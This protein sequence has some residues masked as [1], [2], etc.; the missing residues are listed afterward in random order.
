MGSDLLEWTE[1]LGGYKLGSWTVL[2][3][4]IKVLLK[5][6]HWTLVQT[7]HSW[8]ILPASYSHR[9]THTS[10]PP[11]SL[12]YL[13]KGT[14]QLVATLPSRHPPNRILYEYCFFLSLPLPVM[15]SSSR[16]P[17]IS[18]RLYSTRK[19]DIYHVYFLQS[20]YHRA[21]PI[22]KEGGWVMEE[23]REIPEEHLHTNFFLLLTTLEVFP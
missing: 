21:G 3:V 11:Q 14:I 6:G 23:G 4:D 15:P 13:P 17:S 1:D 2:S 10:L 9:Q 16:G 22:L 18:W 7:Q 20:N 5:T 19:S 8:T 12:S